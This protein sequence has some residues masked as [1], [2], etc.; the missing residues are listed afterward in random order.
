MFLKSE[1]NFYR[2]LGKDN[3]T[4][5]EVPQV[6]SFVDYWANIWEDNETPNK[7]WMQNIQETLQAKV[8]DVQDFVVTIEKLK[9]EIKRERTGQHQA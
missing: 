7:P 6:E 9:K 1:G 4:E 8:V 3:E 5:G 2:E